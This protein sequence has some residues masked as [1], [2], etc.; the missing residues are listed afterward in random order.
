MQ[1]PYIIIVMNR[2]CS[3]NNSKNTVYT[4]NSNRG[5]VCIFCNF[6]ID[7]LNWI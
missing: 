6:Y 4:N 1:L 5:N 7:F 2:T 3:S